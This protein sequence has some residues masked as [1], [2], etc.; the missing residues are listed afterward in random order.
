MAERSQLEFDILVAKDALTAALNGAKTAAG[1]VESGLVKVGSGFGTINGLAEGL[2]G[3]FG[4][5][6]ALAV[7]AFGAFSF[8]EAIKAAEE[9]ETAVRS[10][11]LALAQNQNYS[12]EASK[13]MQDFAS[14]MQKTTRFADEVVLSSA[15]MLGSLTKLNVDGIKKATSASA[16]LAATLGID[17]DSATSLVSKAIEGNTGA[18]S[19]YG[20]Q[21]RKGANE[22]ENYTNVLA[23]LAPFQGRAAADADTFGGAMARMKNQFGEVLESVGNFIIK[24]PLVI[25]A[26]NGMANVF[27]KLADFLNSNKD[28]VIGFGN[29]LVGSLGNALVY[30]NPIIN[31]II[32]AFVNLIGII[33]LVIQGWSQLLQTF[34]FL[35]DIIDGVLQAIQVLEVNLLEIPKS[36]Y[37]VIKAIVEMAESSELVGG[38]LK[39]AGFDIDGLKDTLK[40]A[41]E[42]IDKLQVK[43]AGINID[44]IAIKGLDTV[45]AILGK[46]QDILNNQK[47]IS[48]DVGK[49][50]VKYTEGNNA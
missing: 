24:S 41:T 45:D 8:S 35:N 42:N 12:E 1:G 14:Q 7:A 10:L 40:G 50:I 39:R 47:N 20:I 32:S 6:A 4:K 21:V 29:V 36:F 5:L 43:V 9:Q 34:S 25:A 17:L 19:R 16:D 44:K 38:A 37:E 28:A 11:N 26:I 49:A 30:I 13:G 3:T 48:A 33:R 15:A 23:A 22:T 31:S 46:S 27:A 2:L 18:L